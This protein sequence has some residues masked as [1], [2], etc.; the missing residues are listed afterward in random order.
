MSKEQRSKQKQISI[1]G[2]IAK[3]CRTDNQ[4]I[5]FFD[6]SREA[7]F[8]DLNESILSF[9]E[10][11]PKDLDD[12]FYVYANMKKLSESELEDLRSLSWREYPEI[13]KIFL[14]DFCILNGDIYSKYFPD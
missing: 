7:F 13:F 12:A 9:N 2:E 8:I 4:K 11:I 3:G 5:E 6:S 1:F 14:F 10:E